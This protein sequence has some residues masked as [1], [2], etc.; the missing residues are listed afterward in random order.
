MKDKIIKFLKNTLVVAF[1]LLMST[2][3]ACAKGILSGLVG[4]AIGKVAGGALVKPEDMEIVLAEMADRFNKKTPITVDKNSRMD[5]IIAGPGLRFTYNYTFINVSSKDVNDS[6]RV[7]FI[8]QQAPVTK[9][10]FC[11]NPDTQFFSKNGVTAV[12]SYR[13][14][15][16]VFFAKFDITPKDCGYAN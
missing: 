14:S 6:N 16:G 8:Q 9:S 2:N 4:G 12:Y 7:Y 1:I 13:L 15:D 3:Y 11:S 10:S 5:N